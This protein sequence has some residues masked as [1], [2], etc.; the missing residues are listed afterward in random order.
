M[1]TLEQLSA[2]LVKADAAGNAADAKVFA[3]EIRRMR[4]TAPKSLVDQIPDTPAPATAPAP[5][6]GI[7]D[8]L[9]G[10]PEASAAIGTGAITGL[11]APIVGAG[12]TLLS[13][14]YG[15][16]EGVRIGAEAAGNVAGMA[17]QPHSQTGQ[18]ITNAV[19]EAFNALIPAT[20]ALN[21]MAPLVGP[22]ARQAGNI[23]RSEAD[24]AKQPVRPVAP[25]LAAS[26]AAEPTVAAMGDLKDAHKLDMLKE[27]KDLGV[28]LHPSDVGNPA[29]PKA[30]AA[31]AGTTGVRAVRAKNAELPTD[32]VRSDHPTLLPGDV[33]NTETF[34][35]LR[36]EA[37]KP[38]EPVR[39]MQ[40]FPN[41][42]E[43]KA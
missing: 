28:V 37:A 23:V 18:A 33:L 34:D 10:I 25:D 6:P 22:A 12:K 27:A 43:A 32:A 39:A 11:L 13:G 17:Y 2:A 8:R 16:P 4:G 19:G 24:L 35:R 14:K 41:I 31:V 30:T 9:A 42:T 1:A 20:P 5:R 29:A 15:T 3:D 21:A 36:V 7:L 38:Y 26:R 40:D